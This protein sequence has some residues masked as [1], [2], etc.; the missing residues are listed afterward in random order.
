MKLNFDAIPLVLLAGRMYGG[1]WHLMRVACFDE[2]AALHPKL[3]PD[4][5]ERETLDLLEGILGINVAADEL[6]LLYTWLDFL[7]P[8]RGFDRNEEFGARDLPWPSHNHALFGKALALYPGARVDLSTPEK[9]SRAFEFFMSIYRHIPSDVR[10][11]WEHIDTVIAALGLAGAAA[12]QARVRFRVELLG[13][14][15]FDSD[16]FWNGDDS[17]PDA[18]LCRDVASW[19]EEVSRSINRLRSVEALSPSVAFEYM[20]IADLSP[21]L[22]GMALQRIDLNS[23]AQ[24]LAVQ[25]R[26]NFLHRMISGLMLYGKTPT[27]G[28]LLHNAFRAAL[29]QSDSISPGTILD[30]ELG[31]YLEPR[32]EEAIK[33]ALNG[34]VV[35]IVDASGGFRSP[36]FMTQDAILPPDGL[37]NGEYEYVVYPAQ[38]LH[39]M[40]MLPV[41]H[42]TIERDGIIFFHYGS[43]GCFIGPVN[44]IG[45][46]RALYLIAK[47]RELERSLGVDRQ[48]MQ[49]EVQ[50]IEDSI[51]SHLTQIRGCEERRALIF[52]QIADVGNVINRNAREFGAIRRRNYVMSVDRSGDIISVRYRRTEIVHGDLVLEIPDGV[53]MKVD[54]KRRHLTFI[55]P[56]NAQVSPEG[57]FHPHISGGAPCLGTMRTEV[58]NAFRNKDLGGLI[59]L[60]RLF[61]RTYNYNDAYCQLKRIIDGG[62]E[63]SPEC[64]A[65]GGRHDT[66]NCPTYGWC[67]RCDAYFRFGDHDFNHTSEEDS[68]HGEEVEEAAPQGE[69]T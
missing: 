9:S 60:G 29:A 58:D 8:W 69:G 44:N 53:V 39:M 6:E 67:E 47:R 2:I 5:T 46:L 25:G 32:E 59:E 19:G 27:I 3:Y 41:L 23:I 14:S 64:E 10:G 24:Q 63:D 42:D 52:Q 34:S 66:D 15:W 26:E 16:S 18:L 68:D 55:P 61:L 21:D 56:T 65:C 4:T 50:R 31:L 51:Q 49:A 11:R 28:S 48:A 38:R 7:G 13:V 54:F 17:N 12:D 35:R 43:T 62:D 22:A 30:D 57:H 45:A 20:A 33:R 40:P 37:F 36:M 1:Y